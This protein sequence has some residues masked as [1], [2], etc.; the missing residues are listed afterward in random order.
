MYSFRF[1]GSSIQMF[2]HDS[3]QTPGTDSRLDDTQFGLSY[4]LAPTP[5]RFKTEETWLRCLL[6]ICMPPPISESWYDHLVPV[7]FSPL[8]KHNRPSRHQLHGSAADADVCV[9]TSV[10]TP[11][12]ATIAKRPTNFLSMLLPPRDKPD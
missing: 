6:L 4:T 9:A 3:T 11:I 5:V 1:I 7:P 8:A 10:Q 2:C 12:I